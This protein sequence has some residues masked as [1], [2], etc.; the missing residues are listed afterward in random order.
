M[1]FWNGLSS[2]LPFALCSGTCG[3]VWALFVLIE[4][5]KS[6]ARPILIKRVADLIE[7]PASIL[8]VFA[9][10]PNLLLSAFDALFTDNLL[11]LRGFFRSVKI[12]VIVVF[13][14]SALWWLTIPSNI[15]VW[16]GLPADVYLPCTTEIWYCG[17]IAIVPDLSGD[18]R[19]W[20]TAESLIQVVLA[21]FLYNFFADYVALLAT[22]R[23]LG[24]ISQ[25]RNNYAVI[26]AL[27]L[28]AF[29]IIFIAILGFEIYNSLIDLLIG[30]H[31]MLS[32]VLS[33]YPLM[34]WIEF[35]LYKSLPNLLGKWTVHTISGVF[36]L[37]TLIGIL[38]IV[39][40][41]VAVI[42][43]NITIKI[44]GIGPWIKNNFRVRQYPFKI[45]GGI[46]VLILFLICVVWHLIW[47]V[48]AVVI[49]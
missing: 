37:S 21:S 4:Q 35:P 26:L 29:I 41:C 45:M 9:A 16:I 30:R 7:S 48:L 5:Q 11:S 46:L 39:I 12:S 28:S 13:V 10:L 20:V 3:G 15:R 22:R 17:L 31:I 23:I 47:P 8:T 27:M 33:G 6:V 40:F 49:S 42:I 2:Y 1:N 36:L 38:W 32:E 24:Y 18:G 14:L 44:H 43:S 19:D 34:Q 25:A